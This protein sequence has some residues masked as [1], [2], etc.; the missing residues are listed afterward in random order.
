MDAMELYFDGQRQLQDQFDTRRLADRL[1]EVIVSSELSE[2]D[3]AFITSVDHFFLATVSPDGWPTVSYKGGAPGFVR[4][5]D[6]Q[7][8]AFPNYNGNGMYLSMGNVIE[9]GRVAMLFIDWERRNRFRVHGTA[10]ID[11]ADELLADYP[12]AQFVVR[13]RTTSV[14]PNCPRYIHRMHRDTASEFVPH[15]G[16]QTPV[17]GW[18]REDWAI[19]V[20]PDGDPAMDPDA[21]SA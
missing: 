2:S 15:E 8:L 4:V 3:A 16:K 14:F 17:P 18:K 6:Q 12:E 9:N 21:P 7:T 1:D 11:A 19:D 13:V 5:V 20:L 10:T